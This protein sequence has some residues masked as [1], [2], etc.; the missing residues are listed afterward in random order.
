MSKQMK[1][2]QQFP[3]ILMDSASEIEQAGINQR[4][5]KKTYTISRVMYTLEQIGLEILWNACMR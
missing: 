4:A 1:G 2:M 3:R 5:C